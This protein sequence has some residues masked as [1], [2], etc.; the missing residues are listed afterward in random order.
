M[1]GV[2]AAIPVTTPV[3]EPTLPCA[4]L[5]LLQTPPTVGSLSVVVDPTHTTGKPVMA[6]GVLLTVTAWVAIQP[7]GIVKVIVALPAATPFTIP[8]PDPTVAVATSLLLH[9]VEPDDSVSV[10]L[11][12]VHTANVLPPIAAGNTLTVTGAVV[13]QPVFVIE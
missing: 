12:P 11:E 6:K 5:L 8:V 7:V 13:I 4:L 9:V 1:F 2:P 3:R 10:I